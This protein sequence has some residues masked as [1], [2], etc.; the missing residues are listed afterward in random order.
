[1][2]IMSEVPDCSDMAVIS[3]SRNV[4]LRPEIAGELGGKSRYKMAAARVHCN[5][6][7]AKLQV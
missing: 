6:L 2:T 5:D 4:E 3:K 1:M 7:V